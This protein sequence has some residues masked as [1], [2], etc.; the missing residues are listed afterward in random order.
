MFELYISIN[1]ILFHVVYQG[2]C[3]KIPQEYC[4]EQEYLLSYQPVNKNNNKIIYTIMM[5][6]RVN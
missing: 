3:H 5:Q 2:F 6:K 4:I 1:Y